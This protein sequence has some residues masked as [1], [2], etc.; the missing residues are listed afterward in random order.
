MKSCFFEKKLSKFS[1]FF[2][3]P[4]KKTKKCIWPFRK[5]TKKYSYITDLQIIVTFI[6]FITYFS[7]RVFFRENFYPIDK[8]TS[9][10]I[11]LF[12]I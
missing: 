3:Q 4:K 1:F 10:V 9:F 5:K 8:N 2:D 11:K 12:M 7:I 6:C